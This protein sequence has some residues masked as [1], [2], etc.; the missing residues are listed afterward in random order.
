MWLELSVCGAAMALGYKALVVDPEDVEVNRV[1]LVL[2]GLPAAL[3]GARVVF[4]SDLHHRGRPGFR[5]AWLRA[6]VPR[7]E[8]DLVLLGG[9]LLERARGAPWLFAALEE[10]RPRLGGYAVLGNNEMKHVDLPGFGGRLEAAGYR[11]LRNRALLGGAGREPWAIAGVDDPHRGEDRLEEALEGIPPETFVI[12]LAHSPDG[13]APAVARRIPLV[14]AGHTHGGQVRLPWFGAL[15]T[16]TPR[17]GLRYQQGVYRE[18]AST[19]V[20]TKGLGA[21]GLPIRFLARPEVMLL[22]LV[23]GGPGGADLKPGGAVPSGSQAPVL[24]G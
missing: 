17:T 9:D 11:V 16:N 24:A 6:V 1:R 13:F 20:V 14:L 18:G 21:S 10:W 2:P 8:P 22:E 3:D 15:W 19:L 4:L 5:E 23:R 12:L 7:L